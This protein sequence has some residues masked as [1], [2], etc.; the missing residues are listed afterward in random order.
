MDKLKIIGLDGSAKGLVVEAQFNPKEI[1]IDKPVP[2]QKQKRQAATALEYTGGEPKTMSFE[3]MLDSSESGLSIQNDL[4]KLHVL[5]DADSSFK[6]PPKVKVVWG[7]EGVPGMIPKFEGVIVSVSI[8]Y[9]L[10]DQHGKPLRA[11]INLRFREASKL[12]AGKPQ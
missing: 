3:L 7:D 5:S 9:T 12:K 6:R 10:V 11:V 8:K 1:V 2:W 4:N